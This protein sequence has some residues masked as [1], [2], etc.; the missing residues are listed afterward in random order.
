MTRSALIIGG[1]IGG[2]ACAARLVQDGWDVE[3]RERAAGLPRT[4]TALGMWPSALRALD[5]VGAGDEIRARGHVQRGGALLRPDGRRIASVD[6]SA[7]SGTHDAVRLVARPTLLRT[8]A[9]RLPDG[10]VRF[11][12]EVPDVTLAGG[13]HDVVIAA[14][15]LGSRARQALFGDAYGIRYTGVTSWRGTVDGAAEHASETWGNASRFGITPHEE[16]R[17]NWF[18]CVRAPWRAVAKGGDPAALRTAFGG[19]HADVRRVLDA[20]EKAGGEDVLRHDLCDLERPLPSY[21]RGRVALIGD[22]AHAMTPDLGRGACE[23]LVDGVTLARELAGHRHVED[24]LAAYDALRRR[25]TQRIA[26]AAAVM[27]RAVHTPGVAPFR[28]AALRLL[29]TVGN[30]PA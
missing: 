29:L 6:V 23:A 24:A 13:A 4:G 14:D 8:L 22:A 25:P 21:V 27:N 3:V 2:L 18:A 19:W 20:V 11:D 9:G 7:R 12:S 30:P 1:G 10:V 15:G 26:R 5:A 28:N 17:T 16:G